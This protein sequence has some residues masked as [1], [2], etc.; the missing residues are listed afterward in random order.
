[1]QIRCLI[2][3]RG[4]DDSESNGEIRG[5]TLRSKDDDDVNLWY[6]KYGRFIKLILK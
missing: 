1:M 4:N 5:Q 2:I 6:E 3:Y